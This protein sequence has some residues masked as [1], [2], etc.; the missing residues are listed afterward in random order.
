MKKFIKKLWLQKNEKK[1]LLNDV[2]FELYKEFMHTKYKNVKLTSYLSGGNFA[3]Y[4]FSF[5]SVPDWD[6]VYKSNIAIVPRRF[7]YFQTKMINYANYVHTFNYPGNFTLRTR[8][9]SSLHHLYL[10]KDLRVLTA[11]TDMEAQFQHNFINE[12]K[13]E[14]VLG[15]KKEATLRIRDFNEVSQQK[16]NPF[17]KNN[18]KPK[19]F[20]QLI[21]FI[22]NKQKWR[23]TNLLQFWNRFFGYTQ[24]VHRE[25]Y[26]QIILY[27]I[28]QKKYNFFA[29]KTKRVKKLFSLM[30]KQKKRE[31]IKTRTQ[32][33]YLYKPIRHKKLNDLKF[34]LVRFISW[35]FYL[36]RGSN[37]S[38]DVKS[39]KQKKLF[40]FKPK[41]Q[42]FL[43]KF[44]SISKFFMFFKKWKTWVLSARNV[45][46]KQ[47]YPWSFFTLLLTGNISPRIVLLEKKFN[48]ERNYLRV[49][50]V[51]F[52]FRDKRKAVQFRNP[53][54]SFCFRLLCFALRFSKI[55][56]NSLFYSYRYLWNT[57]GKEENKRIRFFKHLFF[58]VKRLNLR[59]NYMED[60][61]KDHVKSSKRMLIARFFGKNSV[62]PLQITSQVRRHTVLRKRRYCLM[63]LKRCIAARKQPFRPL[64]KNLHVILNQIAHL[65]KSAKFKRNIV[66]TICKYTSFLEFQQ[67]VTLIS[68]F[69]FFSKNMLYTV[70]LN[71]SYFFFRKY[72]RKQGRPLLTSTTLIRP[73]LRKLKNLGMSFLAFFIKNPVLQTN[74]I[75]PMNL[76]KLFLNSIKNYF[77]PLKTFTG[78]H[79]PFSASVTKRVPFVLESLQPIKIVFSPYKQRKR[80]LQVNI[81]NS[82]NQNL[83]SSWP[84]LVI[85][86]ISSIVGVHQAHK[87][88]FLLNMKPK[89]A[90]RN[91]MA[92][93][94]TIRHASNY[95]YKY[96]R[97]SGGSFEVIVRTTTAITPRME[98]SYVKLLMG[99]IYGG[100]DK[101]K[102]VIDLDLRQKKKKKTYNSL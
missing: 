98:D 41:F 31:M 42:N 33:S 11:V 3:R 27:R 55:T 52:K 77:I 102:K 12:I 72:R 75:L 97:R 80:S 51:L 69:K 100:F 54:L 49:S 30:R 101:R 37:F 87:Y 9:V 68:P 88:T 6:A 65:E 43:F 25:L 57:T 60:K 67:M 5:T 28:F 59:L 71:E 2:K 40:F 24:K 93:S 79:I 81:L 26:F 14:Q 35:I 13:K 58:L 56:K 62:L 22:R 50:R 19:S 15:K 10:K 53:F 99:F 34:N 32:I 8:N 74:K 36:H 38:L 29:F 76:H 61:R 7:D 1:I 23:K 73:I 96:L 46:V 91:F 90:K 45:K 44:A 86:K 4:K 89:K 21:K 83:F 64:L 17:S 47:V 20:S 95:L 16:F 85:R 78:Q 82:K 48:L 94:L 92:K 39:L 18:R 84:G 63:V 66:H 70:W